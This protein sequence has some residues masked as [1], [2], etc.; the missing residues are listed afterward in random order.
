MAYRVK[1]VALG[2][3]LAITAC[4]HMIVATDS[5]KLRAEVK[6]WTAFSKVMLVPS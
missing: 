5:L 6:A 4:C 1:N 3:G 2:S